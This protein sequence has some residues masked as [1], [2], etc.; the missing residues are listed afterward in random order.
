MREDRATIEEIR[1]AL[2]G[3]CAWVTR[4]VL[5]RAGAQ[6][7]TREQVAGWARQPPGWFEHE[8][9]RRLERQAGKVTITCPGCGFSI[10][11]KPATAR[12]R[13]H[14]EGL[15][16][17]RNACDYQPP[18]AEGM[19]TVIGCQAVG[20]FT[21]WRHEFP[22]AEEAASLER[23]RSI[24]AAALAMQAGSP[25]QAPLRALIA[26]AGEGHHLVTLSNGWSTGVTVAGDGSLEIENPMV[27]AGLHRM[28][29]GGET[30]GVI[31]RTFTGEI[32]HTLPN[33]VN[34]PVKQIRCWYLNEGVFHP[35]DEGQAFAPTSSTGHEPDY[36][37]PPHIRPERHQRHKPQHLAIFTA[38]G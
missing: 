1:E 12:E 15:Y 18:E 29:T 37:T 6:F 26:P 35:L 7:P 27:A 3:D 31:V 24:A 36:E 28:V 25:V 19:V 23:A 16:C 8:K 32:S 10:T 5:K 13:G 17:G 9:R 34:I 2:G 14:W 4:R 20:S 11:V 22:T 33:G 30:A 38:T 21:G